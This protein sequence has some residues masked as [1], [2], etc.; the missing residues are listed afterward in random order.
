MAQQAA[1]NDTVISANCFK[2]ESSGGRSGCQCRAVE[3]ATS[4]MYIT[5]WGESVNFLSYF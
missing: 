4:N 3:D 1:I 5:N 2:E